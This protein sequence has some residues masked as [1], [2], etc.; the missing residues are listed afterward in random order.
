MFRKFVVTCI[1]LSCLFFLVACNYESSKNEPHENKAANE[2]SEPTTDHSQSLIVYFSWSGNVKEMAEF[3]Q[4]Q[5]DADLYELKPHVEYPQDYD[6]VLTIA[7]EEQENQVYPVIDQPLYDFESYDTIY[8][9]Y[10]IWLNDMPRIL[11]T[12]F[13]DSDLSGK[14]IIPFC[15][16]GSTGLAE[17]VTT[18]RTLENNATILDGLH[19]KQADMAEAYL[20]I[21]TWLKNFDMNEG[22]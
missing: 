22:A 5:T 14:T 6:A 12:F 10:P 3:I 8:I 11:Y 20:T 16:S 21:Q 1:G 18:I 13:K 17:S 7:K 4:K 15:S 9:G 2:V 19:I